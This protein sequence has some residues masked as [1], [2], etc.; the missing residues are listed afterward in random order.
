MKIDNRKLDLHL[1]RQCKVISDLRTVTS[2]Q[3]LTRIRQGDNIKPATLGRIAKALCVDP[4]E[5]VEDEA[6]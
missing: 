1:A 5:L 6:R 2:S 3:T 4:M